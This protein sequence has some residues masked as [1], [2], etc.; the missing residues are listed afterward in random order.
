GSLAHYWFILEVVVPFAP[1]AEVISLWPAR[2]VPGFLRDARSAPA[3]VPP[4]ERAFRKGPIP[5][6]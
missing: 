4:G 2:E 1:V 3:R 5:G 6:P